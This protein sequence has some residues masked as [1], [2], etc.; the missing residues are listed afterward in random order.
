[1]TFFVTTTRHFDR[2]LNKP[3]PLSRKLASQMP[4]TG[5]HGEL[6]KEGVLCEKDAIAIL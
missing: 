3:F 4:L 6:V 1:M 5:K 2:E